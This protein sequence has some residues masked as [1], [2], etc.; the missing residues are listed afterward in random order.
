MA[1]HIYL[2]YIKKGAILELTLL[3]DED[4]ENIHE[5]IDKSRQDKIALNSDLLDSIQQ[6]IFVDLYKNTFMNFI[7][8]KAWKTLQVRI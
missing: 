2:K 6:K 1:T 4:K 3:S 8:T 7:E 5:M